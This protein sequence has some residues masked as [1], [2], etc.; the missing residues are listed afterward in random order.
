VLTAI[1]TTGIVPK[2]THLARHLAVALEVDDRFLG[3]VIEAT[4]WQRRD[5]HRAEVLARESAN[6]C[7]LG[8]L[9]G[10]SRLRHVPLPDDVWSLR[11]EGAILDHFRAQHGCIA[12]F[13]E[14]VGYTMVTLPGYL[15][16]FGIPFDVNGDRAG[17]MCVVQRLSEATLGT[18]RGDTRLTGLLKDAPIQTI[19]VDGQK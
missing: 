13:G 1:L 12:T 14:I 15:V 2:T 18:K 10:V 4:E 5:E 16:D 9:V 7:L 8:A 17:P 11:A 6:R 3:S 19:R